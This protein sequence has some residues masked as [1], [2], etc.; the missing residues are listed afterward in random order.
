MNAEFK[1]YLDECKSNRSQPSYGGWVARAN[2]ADI[3]NAEFSTAFRTTGDGAGFVVVFSPK[4]G[5]GWESAAQLARPESAF[6]ARLKTLDPKTTVVR[7]SVW[8]DSFA[9][10]ADAAAAA[11]KLGFRTSWLPYAVDEE[12]RERVPAAKPPPDDGGTSRRKGIPVDPN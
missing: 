11:R 9:A 1:R 5:G 7:F 12:M 2:R 4:S 8:G 6:A 3:G 10:Y